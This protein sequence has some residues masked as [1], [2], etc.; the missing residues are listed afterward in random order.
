MRTISKRTQYG[1]KAMLALGRRY[2]EGPVLIGTLAREEAIPIKFLEAIL[3]DMKSR[4]LLESKLG[5]KGGY[6]LNRPPSAV[7]IGSIIRII[8][9]PLAPLPCASETAFRACDECQDVENCGTRVIMRRV[10]D[11]IS[12]VLDRTTLADL[13]R[14][15]DSGRSEKQVVES[16]MYHI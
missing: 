10:R 1:L 9:G 14:Q 2:K 15:V 3:L 11:A 16:M 13:L 4:G 5:R 12:E 7:T 8:E 6:Y